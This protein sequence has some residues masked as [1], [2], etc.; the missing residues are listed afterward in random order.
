MFKYLNLGLWNKCSKALSWDKVFITW[1]LLFSPYPKVPAP[2]A[3]QRGNCYSL[4]PVAP[5]LNKKEELGIHS[6]MHC[7][8]QNQKLDPNL[9][10]SFQHLDQ[11]TLKLISNPVYNKGNQSLT[12]VQGP[13]YD[14]ILKLFPFLILLHSLHFLCIQ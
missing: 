1:S 6:W 2:V 11:N 8:L 5:P 7:H 9:S 12:S 3:R 4:H 13:L 10:S 14:T